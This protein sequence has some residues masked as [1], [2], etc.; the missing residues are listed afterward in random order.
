MGHPYF[1]N[2]APIVNIDLSAP[3]FTVGTVTGQSQQSKGTGELNFPKLPSK[4]PVT[5]HIMLGLRHTLIRV[6]PLCDVKCTVKFTRAAVVV[7]DARGMPVLTGWR[8]NSRPRLWRIAL[9]P[10]KEH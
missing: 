2:D 10:D 4:F 7:R 8:E 6:G 9:Q 1:S 3:K 5:G